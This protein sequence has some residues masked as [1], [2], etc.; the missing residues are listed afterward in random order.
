MGCV[1]RKKVKKCEEIV[2]ELIQNCKNQRYLLDMDSF[3]TSIPL[4]DSL[5]SCGFGVTG[6]IR[7]N[8]KGLPKSI[9]DSKLKN[10]EIKM[11]EQNNNNV[12]V[13][14]D[15]KKVVVVSYIYG[16]KKINKKRYAS[17]LIIRN[18]LL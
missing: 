9:I 18:L 14:K 8:R 15:K 6:T 10:G 5:S 11:L 1:Y 16:G 17:G 12:Y 3:F 7:K 4:L 13:W 2:D